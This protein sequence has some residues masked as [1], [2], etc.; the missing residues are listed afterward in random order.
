MP[1]LVV[2]ELHVNVALSEAHA[3][4][5]TV[6]GALDLVP[7]PETALLLNPAFYFGSHRFFSGSKLSNLFT[8][9][10]LSFRIHQ[11]FKSGIN[12]T[13]GLFWADDL[14]VN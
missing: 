3:H 11:L 1:R 8:L 4:A 12:L 14:V 13:T 7:N 6:S 5:G 10:T 2:N 9:L